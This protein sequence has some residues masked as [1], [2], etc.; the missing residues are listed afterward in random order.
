MQ[1][2]SQVRKVIAE[3]STIISFKINFKIEHDNMLNQL[4]NLHS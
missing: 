3:A 4:L 1:T 2:D